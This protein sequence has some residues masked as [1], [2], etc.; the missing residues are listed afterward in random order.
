MNL[1]VFRIF[2]VSGPRDMRDE[3]NP[4]KVPGFT[5]FR[6]RNPPKSFP[7]EKI[8]GNSGQEKRSDQ[9][10]IGPKKSNLWHPEF[11]PDTGWQCHI[12][13]VP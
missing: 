3:M 4:D 1:P 9:K 5:G 11:L 2:P 12:R 10:I 13:Y 8:R 7:R 6:I